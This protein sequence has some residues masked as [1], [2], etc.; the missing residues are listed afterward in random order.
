MRCTIDIN[1][2]GKR[3]G[4]IQ[5][6]HS[7]DRHA[8]G[9]IPIPIAVIAN[10]L[11]PTVLLTA[12][13][14]GD[15]YE[16]VIILKRLYEA[17]A[18][19]QINGRLIIMPALN[20]PAVR[21]F[22]RVSPLDNSNM[23]RIFG[24]TD[25]PGPTREIA[26]FVENELISQARYAIDLHSGGTM[27]EFHPCSYIYSGGDQQFVQEKISAAHCF[28]AKY[29]VVVV[30][31]SGSLSA[32]CERQ[33]VVMLSAELGGGAI[34]KKNIELGYHGT[35]NAL[36]GWSVL[37][38]EPAKTSTE[39]LLSGASS[40]FVMSPIV[41]AFEPLIEIGQTVMAGERVGRVYPLETFSEP[42]I[43]I[44]CEKK[45][46]VIGQRN[47][48]LVQR[49]DFLLHTGEPVSEAGILEQSTS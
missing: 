45:G 16:G 2:N 28:G 43:Q 49:G 27:C 34:R 35:L 18:S 30:G 21:E 47:Q 1:Q 26:R 8:Y 24:S 37:D 6:N 36:A 14:H 10:G 40:S 32:A 17:I 19:E 15:E 42:I 20:F 22:K 33:G 12:G 44:Q 31:T 23:N 3:E 11:E 13:N 41:G 5:L 39:F 46:I 29:T 9:V 48:S 7:N 25:S 4:F 38:S